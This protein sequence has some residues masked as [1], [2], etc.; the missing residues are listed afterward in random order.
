MAATTTVVITGANSFCMISVM[1]PMSMVILPCHWIGSRK[2][3]VPK[4][5]GIINLHNS[6]K[7]YVLLPWLS[8]SLLLCDDPM[9][10]PIGRSDF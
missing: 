10:R 4:T 2:I 5:D 6:C 8:I 7:V 9:F 3:T 1:M